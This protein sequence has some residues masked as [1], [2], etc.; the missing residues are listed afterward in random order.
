M[1]DVIY[2]RKSRADMEMESRTAVD[3]LARHEDELRRN[4]ARLGRTVTAVYR[5]VVS[6]DTITARPMMQRLLYEVETGKWD[7]VHVVETSRLA[8]GDTIDQGI[9]ARAFQLSGTLIVT[10][11]KIVDPRN[12]YDEDYFEFDLFMSR[13]EYKAITRRQQRGR[14]ASVREGKWVAN[15]APYG[16]DRVKIDGEKGWTLAPNADAETVRDIFSWYTSG[17][18]GVSLIVRRLNES[19]VRS[20]SGRDW[21]NCVVRSVLANPAYTGMIAWGRRAGVKSVQDGVVTKSRPRSSEYT[22]V[23]GRHPALVDRETWEA[24]REK[25]AHNKSRP[26][27][28]QMPMMNPLAGLVYCSKCGRAMVRRP[29]GN[30]YPDSLQCIYTSCGT[31]SSTLSTVE[32]AVLSALRKWLADLDA[33]VR[34]EDTTEAARLAQTER[35]IAGTMKDLED[36][37]RQLARIY[38]LTEQ[39]V[40]SSEDFL[41]RSRE[42]AAR[43]EAADARLLELTQLSDRLRE[44]INNR[45]RLAPDLRRVLDAYPKAETPAEK[46]ALLKSVLSRV[47]Y[48][49]TSRERWSSGSDMH[50]DI[51]PRIFSKYSH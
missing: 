48:S 3:V 8:R 24:A 28:K 21:T 45:E 15:K 34:P 16:Y 36:L 9:V 27:P 44:T 2:L 26:G 43:R 30:G 13:R 46:N 37:K 33:G 40:Y 29:Y 38:D 7:A 19:G 4:A 42:N 23:D 12:E 20:P 1:P 5:E 32:E 39:G 35:M 50:I 22:L 25:L 18:L 41:T 6:G 14:M 49:K 31:V 10:P 17:G 51:F 11:S 47:E